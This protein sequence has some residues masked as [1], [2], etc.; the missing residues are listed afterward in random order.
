MDKKIVKGL[1]IVFIIFTLIRI[2]VNFS[3]FILRNNQDTPVEYKVSY[4][5]EDGKKKVYWRIDNDELSF[6]GKRF[7]YYHKCHRTEMEYIFNNVYD[8]NRILYFSTEEYK[9]MTEKC[10]T[11]REINEYLKYQDELYYNYNRYEKRFAEK[12]KKK[13]EWENLTN[14]K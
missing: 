1:I 13:E 14:N 8:A 2:E 6:F 4:H 10:K 7:N 12:R 11:V 3:D 5:T 9:E